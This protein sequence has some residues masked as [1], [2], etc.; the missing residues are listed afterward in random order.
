MVPIKGHD[1]NIDIKHDGQP[2]ALVNCSRAIMFQPSPQLIQKGQPHITVFE[3]EASSRERST[4]QEFEFYGADQVC[5]GVTI[6]QL[7]LTEQ[8]R[9]QLA[10]QS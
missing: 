4:G 3:L 6:V 5:G 10:T 8:L 7:N 2:T 9:R 1:P